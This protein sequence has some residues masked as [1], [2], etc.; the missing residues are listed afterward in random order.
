[1]SEFRLYIPA[2]AMPLN[3]LLLAWMVIGRGLF[4][5]LG[6]M[7]VFG[8]LAA[9]WL[10]LCLVA[11]SRMMRKLPGRELTS[12][13]AWAQVILWVSMF[14]F[15]LAC[16]DGGDSPDA[17]PSVLM[18]V[19]GEGPRMETVSSLLW[20]ASVVVGVAAWFVLLTKLTRG[21]ALAQPPQPPY[22]YPGHLPGYPAP[23]P[24]NG[25]H[26]SD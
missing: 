18:K 19:I 15:G 2:L 4:A 12:G 25:Y 16:V 23:G 1:M 6:W 8:V 5:Q 14:V 21:L 9:P 10:A 13:Q 17:F 26:R 11:T 20:A 3:M 22:P 7:V 24:M